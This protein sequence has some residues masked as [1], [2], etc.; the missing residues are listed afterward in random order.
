MTGFRR[1]LYLLIRV[2][3]TY[4]LPACPRSVICA[5][6]DLRLSVLMAA[7]TSMSKKSWITLARSTVGCML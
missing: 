3:V 6:S 4:E 2:S 5:K 7:N 1:L